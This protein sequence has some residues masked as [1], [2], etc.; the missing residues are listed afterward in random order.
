MQHPLALLL[1]N[2]FR[3]R[4]V[5][6]AKPLFRAALQVDGVSEA[7]GFEHLPDEIRVADTAPR[8]HFVLTEP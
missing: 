4:D 2:R 7:A 8:P 3:L 5:Y 1:P 6:A